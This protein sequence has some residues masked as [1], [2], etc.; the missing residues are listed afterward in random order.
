MR[1]V[2]DL[3]QNTPDWHAFRQG[4]LGSSD[5]AK[6][7]GK[8][9]WGGPI[10]VF[11]EKAGLADKKE[12]NEWMKRGTLWEPEVRRLVE[13]STGHEFPPLCAIHNNYDYA[14]ASLDG[15]NE[16]LG[17]I[18]EIKVPGKKTMDMAKAKE[19]PEH[20]NI[21]IQWQMFVSDAKYARYVCYDPDANE[22]HTWC[23]Y[24]D[25]ALIEEM[26]TVADHFWEQFLLGNPPEEEIIEIDDEEA[27]KMAQQYITYDI[28][29]KWHEQEKK[30]LKEALIEFGDDG[31]FRVGRLIFRR[32]APRKTYDIDAMRVDDIDVDKYLKKSDGIGFYTVKVEKEKS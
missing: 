5:I 19:I 21:Q 20:Y 4:G 17:A 7:M 27:I 28:A 6:L 11:R 26:R 14:R 22:L 13:K 3:E 18:L 16:E 15:F 32:T 2:E 1:I 9:P 12:P 25:E 30:R 8:S 29:S 31:D 23:I 24:R 10:D